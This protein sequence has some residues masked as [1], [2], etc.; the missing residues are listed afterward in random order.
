MARKRTIDPDL[1]TDDRVQALPSL[2]AVLLYIGSISM[3]DDE[4]R[5]EWN[6]RQML[7]RVFPLRDDVKLADVERGMEAVAKSRLV[8]LYSVNGRAYAYHP[9]WRK[10]QYV[11][12]PSKSKIPPPPPNSVPD[13]RREPHDT[14]S[15]PDSRRM[16]AEQPDDGRTDSGEPHTP[17]GSGSGSG[18][19]IDSSAGPRKP[20]AP[21]FERFGDLEPDVVAYVANAAAENATGKITPG[22]EATLR[23]ELADELKTVGDR[24]AFLAGLRIAN[25]AGVANPRYVRKAA[26]TSRDRPAGASKSRFPDEPNASDN[27]PTLADLV[28]A[29][30]VESWTP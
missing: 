6:A 20:E 17:S 22:R 19:S 30:L 18:E 27:L 12:R 23:R 28:D 4:G 5:V 2:T 7:A 25:A 9:A 1:W 21:V 24:A 3:A 16:S 29:G 26:I 10:H 11:N 14:P 13:S 8:V 15:A